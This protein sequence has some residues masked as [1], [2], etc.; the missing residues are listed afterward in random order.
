MRDGLPEHCDS[1]ADQHGEFERG[2]G[3]GDDRR[4]TPVGG[5]QG[6]GIRRLHGPSSFAASPAYPPP[7][8]VTFEG[9]DG[10]G[11]STQADL[12]ADALRAEGRH[13]VA[14]REPGGTELGERIRDLLLGRDGRVSAWA[15]AA[16]FAAAR[17]QLV[18]QVIR[19]AL[20]DGADVV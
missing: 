18:E 7:V 9:I 3:T 5:V 2:D 13:V 6:G 14:T 10:S 16:L 4:G 17:A 12:L 20:G 11:K 8:F 19:P 15:E 1:D